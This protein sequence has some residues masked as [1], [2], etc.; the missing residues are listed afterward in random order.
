MRAQVLREIDRAVAAAGRTGAPIVV[1]EQAGEGLLPAHAA[2]RAWLDLLGDATQRLA[3][4]A[5][6]VD[7]VVAGRPLAL[8]GG[9]AGGGGEG[10]G[11]GLGDGG[12]LG[13]EAEGVR[14]AASG[15]VLGGEA[16]GVRG[17]AS[18]GILGGGA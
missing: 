6:R 8:A 2:S 16:H 10:G 11:E 7:L 14:G 18:G 4:R 9:G 12:V 5:E 13:G 15:G 3:A 17:A 1:A